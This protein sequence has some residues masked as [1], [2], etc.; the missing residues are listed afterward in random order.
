MLPFHDDTIALLAL[1]LLGAVS[2]SLALRHGRLRRG[3]EAL[4]LAIALL[5]PWPIAIHVGLDHVFIQA[6]LYLGVGTFLVLLLG[7]GW[8]LWCRRLPNR[9]AALALVLLPALAAAGYGLERQRVPDAPCAE[10]AWFHI[11]E[12]SLLV[13]RST[14]VQSVRADPSAAGWQGRYSLWVGDKPDVRAYCGVSAGG[15]EPV[16]V[17]HL[18]L[19]ASG[20]V[21]R[22]RAEC[23]PGAGAAPAGVCAAL[24]RT[25]LT[26]VQFYAR[27]D[28]MPGPSLGQFDHRLV[29]QAIAAGEGDGHRCPQANPATG[30]RHC[31]IWHR[32]GP[33]L[34]AVSSAR[35]GL[36]EDGTD[37][38]ADARVL[39]EALLVE[40]R[41]P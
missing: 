5:W 32:L 22:R 1:A 35:L 21:K 10:R 4:G 27:P 40:L 20:F 41:A 38:T 19:S 36:P 13:P 26:V 14:G 2:A 31:T 9:S 8:G 34:L 18:W 12:L 16:S 15:L 7:T 33:Q 11:G 24:E 3:L 30:T 25:A 39:L 6:A 28:G 23:L 29:G 17:A 37:P